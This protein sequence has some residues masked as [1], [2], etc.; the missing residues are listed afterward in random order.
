M[1]YIKQVQQLN[2]AINQ[3]SKSNMLHK[4]KHTN[5][6]LQP[7]LTHN[8][9][10]TTRRRT[11]YR[12]IIK[13]HLAYTY[14][15]QP[16]YFWPKSTETNSI[17]R[18]QGKTSKNLRISRN[19]IAEQFQQTRLEKRRLKTRPVLSR[20]SSYSRYSSDTTLLHPVYKKT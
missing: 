12:D 2:Y 10:N 9:T 11:F 15:G 17:E 8:S 4:D 19:I 1:I 18:N 20:L 14:D 16:T 13:G 6:T 7:S 5:F 3:K